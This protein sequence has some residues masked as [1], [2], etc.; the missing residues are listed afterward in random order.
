M[1]FILIAK[2]FLFFFA[3]API[4][5]LPTSVDS[6]AKVIQVAIGGRHTCVLYNTGDMKCWGDNSNGQLGILDTKFNELPAE[7]VLMPMNKAVKQICAGKNHTC[8][9]LENGRPY[10]WGDNSKGQL[11][12]AI[13]DVQ[14][15]TLPRHSEMLEVLSTNARFLNLSCEKD[16]TCGVKEDGIMI[17]IGEKRSDRL[18]KQKWVR[19][20]SDLNNNDY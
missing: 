1:K 19:Y 9:L 5:A 20:F 2:L 18:Q 3:A 10:C 14:G 7:K 17:C 16:T 12:W 6:N 13:K 11:G 8:A 15:G 4:L